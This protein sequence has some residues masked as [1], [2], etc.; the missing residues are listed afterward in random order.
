LQSLKKILKFFK[1]G[2]YN[3]GMNFSSFSYSVADVVGGLPILK[4]R[5]SAGQTVGYTV[6]AGGKSFASLRA[7]KTFAKRLSRR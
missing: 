6:G 7:A 5:G 2:S 1:K 3:L 4:F